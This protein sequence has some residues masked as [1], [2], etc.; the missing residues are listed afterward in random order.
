MVVVVVVMVVAVV[1]LLLLLLLLTEIRLPS[2]VVSF[3]ITDHGQLLRLN[4]A[5]KRVVSSATLCQMSPT[6]PPPPPPTPYGRI[7]SR[8]RVQ[9]KKKPYYASP[10]S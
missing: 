8:L 10:A 4:L 3:R 2:V 6:P 5:M 9:H 1:A 7:R